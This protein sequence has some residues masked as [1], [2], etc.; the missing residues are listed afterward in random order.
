M[1]DTQ[2]V[3]LIRVCKGTVH[4]DVLCVKVEKDVVYKVTKRATAKTGLVLKQNPE[5]L[6]LKRTG[7]CAGLMTADPT[8]ITS[9]PPCSSAATQYLSR[10]GAVCFLCIPHCALYYI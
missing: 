10:C 7:V 5:E 2:T 8:H 4:L 6:Q 3:G 9:P 1:S